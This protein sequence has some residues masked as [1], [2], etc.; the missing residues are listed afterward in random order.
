MR[1]NMG[2]DRTGDRR[3]ERHDALDYDASHK[4]DLERRDQKVSKVFGVAR[5]LFEILCESGLPSDER[6]TAMQLLAVLVRKFDA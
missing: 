2:G 1:T 5:Q 6:E 3:D 4:A